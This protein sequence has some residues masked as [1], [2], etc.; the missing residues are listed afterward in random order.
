[1]EH[2]AAQ[3]EA[4]QPK[5]IL[6]KAQFEIVAQGSKEFDSYLMKTL[7][8][9]DDEIAI[10]D[11][12]RDDRFDAGVVLTSSKSK[13]AQKV[14]RADFQSVR[15]SESDSTST[16]DESESEDEDGDEDEDD[17]T[18]EV[19]PKAG[20]SSKAESKEHTDSG[21]DFNEY[22]EFLRFKAMLKGKGKKT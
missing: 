14:S 17:D 18:M 3:N 4:G 1:M 6:G 10:R 16:E 19:V 2:E 20:A 15:N 5:P 11:Q 8:G 21:I 9:A 12:W 22:E 7:Q 13:P